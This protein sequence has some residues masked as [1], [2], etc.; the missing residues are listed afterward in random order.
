MEYSI[1]ALSELAGVSARTLRYYDQIGLLRPRGKT[2]AG[3]RLYGETEVDLLQ[4][5]LFY[6]ALG[7]GLAEIARIVQADGFDRLAALKAHLSALRARQA[8]TA[9]LIEA[10][11]KTILS[12]EGGTKMSDTEKF[13]AFKARAVRENE[14]KYGAEV[15]ARYGDE[16]ADAANAKVLG[17]TQADYERFE[18]LKDEVQAALEAAVRAGEAPDGA[19]GGRIVRLHKTWLGYTWKDYTAEA[20]K[21]LAEGYAADERFTAYYDRNVPGC[22]RFLCEAVRFWAKE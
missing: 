20:H 2:E 3:Y 18:A 7:L 9:A 8:Q 1:H 4:Q 22:A 17:M 12:L 16:Q 15:R 13:E 10:V 14:K 19:A 11:Q 6:R 21:A 5:I